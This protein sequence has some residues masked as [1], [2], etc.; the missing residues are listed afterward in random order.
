MQL[1]TALTIGPVDDAA[2]T[3]LL[4]QQ[5]FRLFGIKATTFRAWK[6]L[7]AFP[8]PVIVNGMAYYP[9]AEIENWRRS[10]SAP[11]WL[12]EGRAKPTVKTTEAFA[13]A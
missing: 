6:E 5:I 2:V 12:R 11:G 8:R 7:H 3:H 9:R 1:T 13:P 4:P 10:A